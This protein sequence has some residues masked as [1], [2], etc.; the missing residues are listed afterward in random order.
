LSLDADVSVVSGPEELKRHS[1]I[2]LP[3]VGAFAKGMDHLRKNGM[4][5]AVKESARVG[6][7]LIGLCLGM[8]LLA[9][10]SS[11]FGRHQ[12]LGLVPGEVMR[13]APNSPSCRVPHMG[14]N[15]VQVIR[16]SRLFAGAVP[17]NLTFYFVHSFAYAD[18]ASP[19]VSGVADYAGPVVAAVERDNI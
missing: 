6:R 1:H 3:G 16:E 5:K 2:V 10:E 9:E 15:D 19:W 14:W 4:D 11:E 13:L 12:G 8:Q 18:P 17:A 7:P